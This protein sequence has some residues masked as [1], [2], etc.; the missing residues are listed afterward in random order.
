VREVGSARALYE[1]GMR[2]RHCVAGLLPDVLA[3][4][5]RVLSA[6][7]RGA[8]LTLAVE[9]TGDGRLRLLEARGLDDRLPSSRE[10]ELLDRWIAGAAR[11]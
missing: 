11:V 9:P 2:M 6:V 7:A 10:R 3:G 1:E 4:R 8:P 5:I